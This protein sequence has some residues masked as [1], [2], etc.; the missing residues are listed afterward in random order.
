MSILDRFVRQKPQ[1]TLDQ[2]SQATRD[3]SEPLLMIEPMRR[4]HIRN[5]MPIEQQAYP[6]PWTARVFVEELEQARAGKQIG[7][8]HV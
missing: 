8:A 2:K 1:A 5:I 6:R 7:R 3:L 4:A